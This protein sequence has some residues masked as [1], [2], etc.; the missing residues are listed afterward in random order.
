MWAGGGR[1]AGG[2][3]LVPEAP[4]QVPAPRPLISEV[5]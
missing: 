1:D 4:E 3:R 5:L 2:A